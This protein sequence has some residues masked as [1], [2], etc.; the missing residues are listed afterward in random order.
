MCFGSV[1]DKSWDIPEIPPLIILSLTIKKNNHILEVLLILKVILI[2]YGLKY[3]Q[4][5]VTF[6]LF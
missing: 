6:L 1:L 2:I 4:L 3:L 5:K